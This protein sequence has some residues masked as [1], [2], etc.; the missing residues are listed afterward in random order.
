MGSLVFGHGQ[1]LGVFPHV[2]PMSLSRGGHDS[3]R[4]E[5]ES[6]CVVYQELYLVRRYVLMYLVLTEGNCGG[7]NKFQLQLK[8]FLSI[9]C[10]L[11]RG[12]SY[13]G[14]ASLECEYRPQGG[15]MGP[16]VQ[17]MP[18]KWYPTIGYVYRHD[19]LRLRTASY[20]AG[21]RL[22]LL[23][24]PHQVCVLDITCAKSWTLAASG[25]SG[26]LGHRPPGAESCPKN[27]AS[28]PAPTKA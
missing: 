7:A 25:A 8:T 1:R 28:E 17:N 20:D 24:Y 9:V 12:I 5:A 26:G 21:C 22:A 2:P 27:Q 19:A 3:G 11:P 16:P 18:I 23:I 15:A 14:N 10:R 13:L 4:E 6:T